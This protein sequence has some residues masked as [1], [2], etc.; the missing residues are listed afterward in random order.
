[1]AVFPGQDF[2]RFKRG[3]IQGQ[4]FIGFGDSIWW[5]QW[6]LNGYMNGIWQ[7]K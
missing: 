7:S 1:M 6:D 3:K 5:F 2:R 4:I